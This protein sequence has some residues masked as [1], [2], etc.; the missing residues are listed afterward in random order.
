MG[1]NYDNPDDLDDPDLQTDTGSEDEPEPNHDPDPYDDPE[2]NQPDVNQPFDYFAWVRQQRTGK[3]RGQGFRGNKY[4]GIGN[5]RHGNLSLQ[6]ARLE[7]LLASSNYHQYLNMTLCPEIMNDSELVSLTGFNRVQFA[8]LLN[9]LCPVYVREY[10]LASEARLL[11]YLEK[12]RRNESFLAMGSR[13]SMSANSLC[14]L[15]WKYATFQF[16]HDP[17]VPHRNITPLFQL[18]SATEILLEHVVQDEY[19]RG[20]FS[21]VVPPDEPIAIIILDATY[22]FGPKVSSPRH[23]KRTFF[24][25][26]HKHCT[27]YNVLVSHTG[28]I[29]AYSPQYGSISPDEGDGNLTTLQLH[30]EINGEVRNV[31]DQLFR[32]TDNERLWVFLYTDMGY[33]IVSGPNRGTDLTMHSYFYDQ[34]RPG[35]NPRSRFFTINKANGK[36]L[37][38]EFRYTEG[39]GADATMKQPTAVAASNRF[40]SKIRNKVE[41]VFG[42]ARQY[43]IFDSRVTNTK[44]FDPANE[45]IPGSP[46]ISA[47]DILMNNLFC[48]INRVFPGYKEQW[49]LPTGQNWYSM[50]QNFAERTHMLNEFDYLTH[51][52]EFAFSYKKMPTDRDPGVFTKRPWNSPDISFPQCLPEDMTML[53]HGNYQ[54]LQSDKYITGQRQAEVVEQMQNAIETSWDEFDTLSCEIPQDLD[55]FF[56]DEVNVPGGWEVNYYGTWYPRRQILLQWP[57]L[58]S[59]D[60]HKVV[61]S[62]IPDDPNWPHHQS[63]PP[64]HNRFGFSQQGLANLVGYACVSRKCKPGF[65][66]N[67]CCCHV[68]SSV[69]LLGIYRYNPDLFK[70][71]HKSFHYLDVKNHPSLNKSL[72]P[73]LVDQSESSEDSE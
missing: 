12:L 36:V 15:F 3:G 31:F 28:K 25:S 21:S 69:I 65:R 20:I 13:R 41:Q 44:F 46:H 51:E 67:G 68:A 52:V 30:Y 60:K 73:P 23:Q 17:A 27:K 14:E 33:N 53:C 59:G 29:I 37:N 19:I 47:E 48:N 45:R 43:R 55:V 61:L 50:G 16:L 71:K 7:L 35:Y 22:I 39:P 38:R 58:H 18:P 57:S 42:T 10:K 63:I 54:I 66:L 49:S 56:F 24:Q 70:S 6:Q 62:I 4:P 5:L 72:C 8:E 64:N 34:E 26:K 1:A 9:I 32:P 40:T 11:A 2:P